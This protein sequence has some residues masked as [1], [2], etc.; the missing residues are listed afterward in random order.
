MGPQRRKDH[1][2]TRRVLF[3]GSHA[4]I[5]SISRAAA[6]ACCRTLRASEYVESRRRAV[7]LAVLEKSFRA[8]ASSGCL[9]VSSGRERNT[10]KT[11]SS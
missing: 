8:R 6:R 2:R 9:W 4:G 3:L 10:L 5:C 1:A 7:A 11:V